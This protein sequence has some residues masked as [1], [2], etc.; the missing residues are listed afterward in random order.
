MNKS[1]FTPKWYIDKGI[2]QAKFYYVIVISILVVVF[3]ASIYFNKYLSKIENKC[4]ENETVADYGE[5]IQVNNILK[6]KNKRKLCDLSKSLKV[7]KDYEITNLNIE[8]DRVYIQ[9]NVKDK[10]KIRKLNL[11]LE[12]NFNVYEIKVINLGDYY[13]LEF[14]GG[15]I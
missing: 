9:F 10:Y 2:R 3:L 6:E 13:S 8:E 15:G 4:Y 5:A 12:K 1:D 14:S 7:G 11:E